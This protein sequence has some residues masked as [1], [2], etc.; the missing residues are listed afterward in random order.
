MHFYVDTWVR[1]RDATT[2]S[3][4]KSYRMP[5]AMM[6]VRLVPLL[7]AGK[8][9]E[10]MVIYSED[11]RSTGF[12]AVERERPRQSPGPVAGDPCAAARTFREAHQ[13]ATLEA[14]K[15]LLLDRG[16]FRVEGFD[17]LDQHCPARR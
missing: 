11:L 5:Q 1:M 10:L 8:R 7:H 14:A 4:S 12:T 3:G 2:P 9:K 15:S 16:L 17:G 6:Y 13:D